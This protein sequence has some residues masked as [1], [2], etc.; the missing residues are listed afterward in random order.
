VGYLEHTH[1]C[2]SDCACCLVGLPWLTGE[3]HIIPESSSHGTT[4]ATE[5]ATKVNIQINVRE[6]CR[7]LTC[8]PHYVIAIS[9][10]ANLPSMVPQKLG[11]SKP[12]YKGDTRTR[13][14]TCASQ[15]PPIPENTG[16]NQE[17]PFGAIKHIR[18]KGT[19]DCRS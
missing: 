11:I 6:Q 17:F 1:P 2:V 18:V 19:C 15:F 10:L 7:F 3:E 16:Y 9:T 8:N 5:T 4:D 12:I 14:V 13:C